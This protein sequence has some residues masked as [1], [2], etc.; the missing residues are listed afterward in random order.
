M[1]RRDPSG[2][3]NASQ[4]PPSR[5]VL[6]PLAVLGLLW[7]GFLVGEFVVSIL[8]GH[9]WAGSRLPWLASGIAALVGSV[10]ILSPR[11]ASRMDARSTSLAQM[12]ASRRDELVR[13]LAQRSL[14]GLGLLLILEIPI[15]IL[16]WPYPEWQPWAVGYLG[17]TVLALLLVGG[18]WLAKR[19]VQPP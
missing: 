4:I 7:G 17:T 11:H 12:P 13:S 18:I 1:L 8:S 2:D 9:P 15:A 14:I 19:R 16:A 3:G 10:L 6:R 5:K